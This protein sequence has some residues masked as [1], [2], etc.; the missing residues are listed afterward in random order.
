MVSS[1]ITKEGPLV[2]SLEPMSRD[3]GLLTVLFEH[4]INQSVHPSTSHPIVNTGKASV[5]ENL[6][7]SRDAYIDETDEDYARVLRA[8]K[9]AIIRL[10]LTTTCPF[11]IWGHTD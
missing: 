10:S 5:A 1:V 7:R 9:Y 2:Y 11:A 4:P 3:P 8:P 6:E